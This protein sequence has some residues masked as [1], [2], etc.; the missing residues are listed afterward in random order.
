LEKAKIL[1]EGMRFTE[2]EKKEAR[3]ISS[4]NQYFIQN[5]GVLGDVSGSNS[6]TIYRG[7]KVYH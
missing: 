1:G 7:S 5:V 2:I 4:A 6:I 3:N